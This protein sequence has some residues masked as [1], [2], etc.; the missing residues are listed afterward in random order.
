MLLLSERYRKVRHSW[1]CTE[2]GAV[3]IDRL[4]NNQ[5]LQAHASK[6]S[7]SNPEVSRHLKAH[8]PLHLP[9]VL[10]FKSLL[11]LRKN[12]CCLYYYHVSRRSVYCSYLLSSVGI[13]SDQWKALTC[14][15]KVQHFGCFN[16]VVGTT[17][18]IFDELD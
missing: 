9:A 1:T 7:Q 2:Y 16:F 13:S 8:E 3:H 11:L 4:D 5:S 15:N 10:M 6:F 14:H 17:S 12:S 18:R